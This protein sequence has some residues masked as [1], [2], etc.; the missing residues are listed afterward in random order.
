MGIKKQVFASHSE[1][2]NYYKLSRHWGEKYRIYHNLPVLNI[3]NTEGL[4]EYSL[5]NPTPFKL[6][7][8]DI[9]RLK[10]TS[11]DYTLCN[12]ADEPLICI[13]FDGLQQG[14]NLGTQYHT[15]R[16]SDTWRKTITELKLRVAHGSHFPYFILGS[17]QFQDLSLNLQ[18]TLVDGIVGEVLGEQLG[19][20]RIAERE[21]HPED[22][23]WSQSSFDNLSYQEQCEIVGEWADEIDVQARVESNPIYRRAAELAELVECPTYTAKYESRTQQFNFPARKATCTIQ[24]EKFGEVS[25]TIWLP[26]FN[27]PWFTDLLILIQIARLLALE[28]LLKLIKAPKT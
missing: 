8:T 18:L 10:K 12:E 19:H 1:R 23:G 9:Q 11:I 7:E 3:F 5:L 26:D 21:F 20:K 4:E 17:T 27:T 14:F 13:D 25:E 2:V 16:P 28:K 22:M 6:T 15:F 24:T